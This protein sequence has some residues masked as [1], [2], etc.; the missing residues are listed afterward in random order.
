M[1]HTTDVLK[2]SH[3]SVYVMFF[4]GERKS[5]PRF[6]KIYISLQTGDEWIIGNLSIKM[7]LITIITI[8]NHYNYNYFLLFSMFYF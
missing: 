5:C 3:I 7:I 4:I 2:L 6:K 8:T 1:M